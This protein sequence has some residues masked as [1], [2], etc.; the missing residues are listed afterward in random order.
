[1]SKTQI[2]IGGILA[3]LENGFTRTNESKNYNVEIGCIADK[4]NLTDYDIKMLFKH[5]GLKGKKT[6]V[7][8]TKTLSF[9]IVDVITDSGNAEVTTEEVQASSE[10]E[11]VV[12]AVEEVEATAV[13]ETVVAVD[14]SQDKW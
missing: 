2:T 3:D 10:T 6:R 11:T 13:V 4:Y 7:S 8:S 9:E 14:A 5:E 1:M 12:A